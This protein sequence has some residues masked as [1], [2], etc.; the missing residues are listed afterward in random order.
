MKW[1]KYNNL[2]DANIK[3]YNRLRGSKLA[4]Q[5]IQPSKNCNAGDTDTQTGRQA[6]RLIDWDPAQPDPLYPGTVQK[7]SGCEGQVDSTD[8]DFSVFLLTEL[9]HLMFIL[10]G[11]RLFSTQS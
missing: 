5:Q 10:G 2:I 9:K 8:F 3:A 7:D 4:S 11:W 6:D 1:I